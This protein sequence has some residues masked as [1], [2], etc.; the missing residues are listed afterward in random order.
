VIFS[1]VKNGKIVPL[2]STFE[3][4]ANLALGKK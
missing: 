3:D 2:T 4:V 1:Q